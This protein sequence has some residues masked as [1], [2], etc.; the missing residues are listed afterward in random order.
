MSELKNKALKGVFW[1]FIESISNQLFVFVIGIIIAR[2]L[3]PKEF[4]LIGMVSVF[5]AISQTF[6]DSGFSQALIRKKN[7]NQTDYSTVFIFNLVVALF[8]YLLLFFGAGYISDYFKEPQ[9]KEIVRVLAIGIIIN[10]FI[11]IQRTILTK[12]I[13]FKLQTKI[14]VLATILSG[15]LGVAMAYNNYGV[16]SLVIKSISGLFITALFFWAWNKWRPKLI[17]SIDSFKEL[18]GFGSKLL[19]G[20]LLD[21][22]FKNIYSIVIGKYFTAEQLGYYTRADQFQAL[23]SQNIT[24]IINRVSYP[25]LSTMQD[26]TAALKKAYKKM[27]ITTMYI[28][29]LSMFLLAAIAEPLVHFLIGSKWHQTVI[30]LQ[31]LCFTGIFFPLHVFNLNI[32]KVNGRTHIL[33]KLEIIKKILFVPIIILGVIYGIKTLIVGLIILN[34]V[35]YGLNSFF[36]G[37]F[38]NYSMLQQIKDISPSLI[39]AVIVCATVFLVGKFL[40]VANI[41]KIIIQSSLCAILAL[42]LSEVLKLESYNY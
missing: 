22:V 21:T 41:F 35:G 18:F 10:A 27:I 11:L 16:W 4:G 12:E 39:L 38:I 13:N 42:G 17:F 5:M 40:L 23:P 14:S 33:L 26:D 24:V 34:I 29:F 36:S 8:I 15:L 37:K 32:L 7:C 31:L 3:S 19:I 9:L 28:T 30:Y 6:I 25:I 2:I 1:S 20:G